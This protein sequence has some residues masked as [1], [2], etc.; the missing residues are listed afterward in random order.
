M[1]SV[2][3]VGKNVLAADELTYSVDNTIRLTGS[4]NLDII[5][6]AG[7]QATT[8]VIGTTT[9][10]VTVA[11]GDV[12][13]VESTTLN[14][15]SN[16]GGFTSQCVAGASRLVINGTGSAVVVTPSTS[17]FCVV[18]TAGGGSPY[19][20]TTPAA[21]VTPPTN[22]SVVIAGGVAETT[23]TTVTLTLGATDAAQMT[24]SESVLFAGASWESYA[25]SKSFTLSSGA[26]VKTVYAKFKDAAGNISTAVSDMI[27]LNTT[28]VQQP[29]VVQPQY[30]PQYEGGIDVAGRTTRI[31]Q[32]VMQEKAAVTTINRSLVARVKGRILLQA[33]A[34]G[35]AWYVEPLSSNKFYLADG[36][37]AYAALRKFGLGITNAN[38]VKIPVGTDTRFVMDDT[39]G[40]GLPDKLEEG[41]GTDLFNSD[42]DGDGV[43]DADEVLKK[44]TNPLSTGRLSYNTSL[45]NRLKGRILLQTESRGEAWYVNPVDGKRYYLANGP[46]A[47]QIMRFLS[48]GI[49]NTDLR[50]IG[51]GELTE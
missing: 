30:E 48:L 21:D 8:L 6:R 3:L 46:A 18:P 38:L 20:P 19:V 50:K 51:V 35:E 16:D 2:L 31:T 41:L 32:V 26:G 39:D 28:G 10:T 44:N 5:I 29:D 43:S 45:T 34:N 25:T 12:F 37:S 17:S 49:T 7:S 33:E 4:N 14:T 47:Y 9:F 13:T 36:T 27:T 11:V 1:L 22:T 15:L 24:V 23:S 42:T 40:D